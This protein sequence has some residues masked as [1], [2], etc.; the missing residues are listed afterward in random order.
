M[1]RGPRRRWRRRRRAHHAA[2]RRHDVR[3]VFGG[4]AA[5]ADAAARRARGQRQP[6][7]QERHGGVRPGGGDRR[8]RSW[9]SSARPATRR[10]CRWPHEDGFAEQ[11]APRP[12][13][14]R[15]VPRPAPQGAASRLAAGAVRDG[16]VDAADDRRGPRRA[17]RRV[18]RPVHAVGDGHA[19]AAAARRRCR[20]L[21]AADPRVLS[22]AALLAITLGRHG[23][24]RPP[25]L[26]ARLGGA[27]R[28]A[29]R[30]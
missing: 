6:D 26:H 13:H 10:T 30:T 21:F 7:A 4:G 2:R 29:P 15:G 18:G 22:S 1:I 25:L 27:A 14:R 17:P 3:R 24:G 5:R 16:R 11:A 8:R 9:R 20:W 28:T 19:G 12:C 23:L